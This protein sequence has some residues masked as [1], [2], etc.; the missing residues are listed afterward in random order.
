MTTESQTQTRKATRRGISLD[1]W[2][3]GLA[4]GEVV[5]AV[6]TLGLVYGAGRFVH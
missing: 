1:T 6:L 3:V 2:A 4:L 5:I